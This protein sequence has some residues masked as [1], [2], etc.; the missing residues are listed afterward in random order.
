MAWPLLLLPALAAATLVGYHHPDVIT[1]DL[2]NMPKPRTTEAAVARS[3]PAPVLAAA[4]LA[5]EPARPPAP[6]ASAKDE[7]PAPDARTAAS[8]PEAT[9]PLVEAPPPV[10]ASAQPADPM[11][12]DRPE[13]ALSTGEILEVQKRLASLGI[14]P[15]PLDGIAGPRTVAGAE[16]YETMRG[17]PTSGKIDRR[18][19]RFLQQETPS[20]ASSE[21]QAR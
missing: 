16:R 10:Q 19:L 13:V 21:A 18:L 12:T 3:G 8:M 11:A 4:V 9:I 17:R 2:A 20:A 15:G 1:H 6:T 14:D 5:P 7:V